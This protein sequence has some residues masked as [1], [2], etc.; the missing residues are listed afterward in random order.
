[1][2]ARS[3]FSV[4]SEAYAANRP[5][6]PPALFSWIASNCAR[7]DR[8]WDC[9]A[10]NGQAA[11]GLA[12]H[13]RSVEATDISGEQLARGLPA[14]NIRYSVQA[15]E[16]TDFAD[17]GF[18]LVAVAQALHWFDFATF[19]P[20]VRRVANRQAFFCAWGYSWFEAETDV[21]AGFVDGMLDVLKPYWAPNNRLLWDGYRSDEIAFPFARVDAPAFAIDVL[22]DVGQLLGYVRTWSAYKRAQAD[23]RCARILSKIEADAAERLRRSGP[24]RFRIP[25]TVAAGR[26]ADQFAR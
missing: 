26:I 14:P 4:A 13:F 6:Y 20:E 23:E 16:R 9:G 1:M 8:A 10:G 2:D 3:T 18:D 24:M 12:D 25:L 19:W 11:R 17:A 15:A 5:A 21:Q 22:W 7:R